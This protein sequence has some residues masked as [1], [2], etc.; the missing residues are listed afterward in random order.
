MMEPPPS[1]FSWIIMQYLNQQ[2]PNQWIG[3]GGA[4]NW[5]LQS[6]DLNLLD[7]NACGYV[8]VTAYACKVNMSDEL[9]Q[10]I[11]NVTRC[12][13]NTTVLQ[14]VTH[15][16][17]TQVR[18]CIQADED[19]FKQLTSAVKYII[20]TVHL[21]TILNKYTTY[22]LLFYFIQFP[23]NTHSSVTTANQTHM[24]MTFLTQNYLC[25]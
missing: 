22:F 6:P 17:V 3:C 20:I 18:K 10:W 16:L 25:N 24:Y 21:T 4:Q 1:H 11:L 8:K 2:L 14:K 19:H 9:L 5:P 23:V 7:Y 13:N 12:I 15:F